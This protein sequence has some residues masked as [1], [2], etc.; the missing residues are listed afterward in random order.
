MIISIDPGIRGTGYAVWDNKWNLIEHGILTSK[1]DE[2]H[3]KFP[4][5]SV[6]MVRI[7]RKHKIKKAYIE[8]PQK[9][10]GKFGDM[11]ANRGDLVKLSMFVGFLSGRMNIQVEC[12]RVIDWKGTLPK[13]VV[14]KRV[15]RL[16]P[17]LKAK[18][19]AIDAIGIGL[20]VK[21]VF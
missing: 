10:Q 19:H 13:D 21:G 20:Y 12:V 4:D 18:S 2:W 7:I 17:G 8:E 11:V 5:L 1:E 9:F 6:Q 16:I 14:E 15:E 3:S